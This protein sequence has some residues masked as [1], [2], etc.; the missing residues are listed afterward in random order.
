MSISVISANEE[1]VANFTFGSDGH[2]GIPLAG[3]LGA[4]GSSM[5]SLLSQILVVLMGC[6]LEGNFS[7][8]T[9]MV[10]Q[11]VSEM[12]KRALLICLTMC[13]YFGKLSFN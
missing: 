2:I 13:G 10:V 12:A 6:G 9:L 4:S 8:K 11:A 1:E 3:L 7:A 5:V